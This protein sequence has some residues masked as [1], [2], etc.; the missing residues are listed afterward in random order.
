[1]AIVVTVAVTSASLLRTRQPQAALAVAPFDARAKAALAGQKLGLNPQRGDV[2][3]AAEM[4]RQALARDPTVV[5][6]WRNLAFVAAVTGRQVEA[7]RLFGLSQRLSRRDPS[8]QLW[9]IEDAVQRNDIPGALGHYDIALRTSP[10]LADTLVPILVTATSDAPVSAEL[11]KLL[12]RDPPWAGQY[13]RYLAGMLPSGE[14]AADL[15]A[16]VPPQ[17]RARHMDWLPLLVPKAIEARDYQAAWRIYT[18]LTR[19][20][21]GALVRDGAF[22]RANTFPPLEWEFISTA[23]FRSEPAGGSGDDAGLRVTASTGAIGTVVRQL[24]LLRPGVYRLSSVSATGQGPSAERLVWQV[25][26]AG[27][28]SN[29]AM[30]DVTPVQSRQNRFQREF[31]VPASNCEAQWLAL[32]V[33]AP[34]T[35]GGIEAWVR[36]VD[37]VASADRGS[38]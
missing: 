27:S 22:A 2:L 20:E 12:A 34:E 17:V 26:C 36:Q 35:P 7:R 23:D 30:L 3:Q 10:A 37:I 13:F 18:M 33:A 16:R 9:L 14:A 15:L 32:E 6:A 24:L 29:L 4:S 38:R 5:E 25:R 8:T 21:G 11:A 28:N 1:M 19:G 31:R